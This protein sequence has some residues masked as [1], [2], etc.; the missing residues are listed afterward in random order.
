MQGVDAVIIVTIWD[1]F[2]TLPDIINNMASQPLLIDGRR[3]IDKDAVSRYDGIGMTSR[4]A[5]T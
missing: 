4:S 2:H 5:A 3:M 1:E